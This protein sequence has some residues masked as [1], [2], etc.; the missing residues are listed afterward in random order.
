MAG[1]ACGLVLGALAIPR[2][3]REPGSDR[4][5]DVRLGLLEGVWRSRGYGWLWAVTDGRV[6]V[7]DE[8]GRYCIAR[9]DVRQ[10][11]ADL[12]EGFDLSADGQRLQVALDD[13]A[14]HASFRG[15]A[16]GRHRRARPNLHGALR[17]LQ[18]PPRR[19]AGT[20]QRR[21]QQSRC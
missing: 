3:M 14:L 13:P 8:S 9:P 1:L 19:L 7:F 15:D 5:S 20:H 16:N 10:R 18:S 21:P 12:D 4:G 11:L 17:V 2:A 6:S